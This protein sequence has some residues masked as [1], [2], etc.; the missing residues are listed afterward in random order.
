MF[1]RA[2]AAPPAPQTA[3]QWMSSG[4]TWLIGLA[5]TVPGLITILLF[6]YWYVRRRYKKWTQTA[7]KEAF[8]KT[9]LD[10]SGLI[11]ADELYIG[12]CEAY[13]KLHQFG[14]NVRAPK[15]ERVLFALQMFDTD[16]S[17]NISREEF[18][19]L[20]QHLLKAQTSRIVTQVALTILCPITAGYVC[21]F[22]HYAFAE[23]FSSVG[24]KSTVL[25]GSGLQMLIDNVP[26][27]MDETIVCSMMMLSVNPIL[28]AIEER[29][30]QKAQA[31]ML[32]AP[33][34]AKTAAPTMS[35]QTSAGLIAA[36]PPKATPPS[37]TPHT[38]PSKVVGPT[39]LNISY[40][41]EKKA[42]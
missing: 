1:S 21:Q 27:T 32:P 11:S 26:S 24:V 34:P 41:R 22:L 38:P 5:V 40:S 4:L 33:P 17:G 31:E 8:E 39:G 7:L 37:S 6:T 16:N 14:L 25:A 13:L 29:F 18:E 9:D 15:R 30:A 3:Q 35:T 10:N 20:V 42:Q 19:L 28:G 36:T 23:A 2:E 12:V